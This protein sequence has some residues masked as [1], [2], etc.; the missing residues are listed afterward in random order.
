MIRIPFY[1]RLRFKLLLTVML[2]VT[3]TSGLGMLFSY[4]LAEKRFTKALQGE[5]HS[6]DAIT[7]TFFELFFR[8]IY[9][10]S[11]NAAADF[12]LHQ[13]LNSKKQK[14]TAE[15][16]STLCQLN[17]VDVLVLFNQAGKITATAGH[18]TVS[19]KTLSSLQ[20]AQDGRM[21]NFSAVSIVRED[22]KL[23]LYAIAPVVSSGSDQNYFILA[24]FLLTSSFLQDLP[25]HPHM[26]ISLVSGNSVMATTL[27]PDALQSNGQ[28]VDL[29]QS[30]RVSAAVGRIQEGSLLGEKMYVSITPIPGMDKNAA[31]FILLSH[32]QKQLLA[33]KKQLVK[34]FA[35]TFLLGFVS[36][37]ILLFF[38]TASI[39]S[40]IGKLK[41]LV[42]RIS[43]GDL[44]NRIKCDVTN[45]FTP[46]INQ[47]N[48]MLDAVQ[49]K[50]E[51][52]S[53]KV[54]ARTRKLQ[55]Q[56]VFI[57]NLLRSSQ[58]MAIAA[59][60][61]ELK[62]T[63]FNPVAEEIFGYPVEKVIGRKVLEFHPHGRGIDKKIK[64]VI[65][66]LD[67]EDSH[68][69]TIEQENGAV[70]RTIEAT[71]SPVKDLSGVVTGFLLMAQDVSEAR[72][73]E[74]QLRSA[75]TELQV[76][77]DNTVL[78]LVLVRDDHVL[79]V[80]STFEKMFGYA[81]NELHDLA[82]S[83]FRSTLFVGEKIKCW[84]SD[85]WMFSLRKKD[86]Q[87]FW[88]KVRQVV[89]ENNSQQNGILYFFED[90][91][92]QKEM[93][94]KIQRL[95]QAVEQSSN[96]VVIT[97]TEG[98]IEYV[99]KTFVQTTGYSAEEAL[100]QT[101]AILQS[102]LTPEALYRDMWL[103]LKQGKEWTGEFV[104]KK[105]SGELY[106]EHVVI[107]PIRDEQNE[108]T[109]FVA[110]KENITDLKKAREQADFAN[111]AKG[112]FLAN[113]SH[114]I[115]TPMNAI[116]GMTEL[117]LDTNLRP[118][119][120]KY[121]DN[122]NSSATL[123]L[124]LINDILDYS[125]IEAG[126]LEL[127]KRPFDPRAVI[128]QVVTTLSVLADQKGIQLRTR[129]IG[130][131]DTSCQPVG[132]SLRLRQILLNLIGNAIKFTHEGTVTLEFSVQQVDISH[133]AGNFC[134]VR[135]AIHDTGIGIS[136]EQ[137]KY[138]FDSFTQADSTITRDF[139]GTGLG[140]AISSRLVRMM[141]GSL[142]LESTPGK[143]SV[144]SFSLLL[145]RDLEQSV[146]API[147]KRRMASSERRLSILLVEDNP[148]NQELAKILL[149]REG[150]DVTIANNGLEALEFLSEQEYD[151]IF[152]DMQM[153]VMDGLTAT[154]YIR[155]IEQGRAENIP[156]LTAKSG[157]LAMRL[158]GHHTHI[159][160]VTANAM[161]EDRQRCFDAGMDDYLS[162]PY[163]KTSLQKILWDC[164]MHSMPE[165][166]MMPESAV[167]SEMQ[168]ISADEVCDHL[169]KS[170]DLD[171]AEAETVLD[172][173]CGS[174]TDNLVNLQQALQ[175]Q[176]LEEASRQA[177]ALKG[178][179]LNL[180]L[181]EL[182]DTAYALEKEAAGEPKNSHV[183]LVEQ[184]I[185][186]LQP[187]TGTYAAAETEISL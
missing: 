61:I 25:L 184:L 106:E 163:K 53:I 151:L 63:Y 20:M 40:P 111:Q 80:N 58:T 67:G 164:D 2:V 5:F 136:R 6:T 122:V 123:L 34:K 97:N 183:L 16:L 174:L 45:E 103:T 160:A 126:R 104:N 24:G 179:L 178:A 7:D 153:P 140:L 69:F 71:V 150:N 19:E 18:D 72:K 161:Q 23:L 132:D 185:D 102:G 147:E 83:H 28:V 143:G 170:F 1:K 138:I 113:M 51:E 46:L 65:D 177:H 84:D 86:K 142:T 101:P 54:A 79:R 180:G 89:I 27:A 4:Q 39:L 146:V 32:S 131:D 116:I 156:E 59:T 169:M 21:E 172:T 74:K 176:Q 117:L 145:P 55:E 94:E 35:I 96:S 9:L 107:S 38:V 120:K 48:S 182:A 130:E 73:M 114:E 81:Q 52:L 22:D 92:S 187:I 95:G 47:F 118:E 127:E 3:L 30:E 14:I 108:I 119:Q 154:R 139:G 78:G 15:R 159:I 44:N 36:T 110:T 152:M 42:S 77:L 41:E 82:W 76:I 70:V 75:L 167:Q 13:A 60:D 173:Y 165:G 85:G 10:V 91:S 109:H 158:A 11:Q 88:G 141:G 186:K 8:Q 12:L 100:G 49:K 124:S 135:F 87:L 171:R 31:V 50:D 33:N 68:T 133:Y 57:D 137:Q 98:V 157:Q 26:G 43:E 93:F 162:K 105:K 155:E 144:F 99:N 112:E 115:R 37:A 56:H 66:R 64:R 121:L 29:G 129:A 166:N 128:K 17:G 90:M 125:K 134:T 62:I 149:E 168:A 175:K 148:A 181:T